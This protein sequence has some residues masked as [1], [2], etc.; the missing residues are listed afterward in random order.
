LNEARAKRFG[1]KSLLMLGLVCELLLL[2]FKYMV[3]NRRN[4]GRIQLKMGGRTSAIFEVDSSQDFI[5]WFE[6]GT[7]TNANGTVKGG[8]AWEAAR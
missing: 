1:K 8:Q 7:V 5:N 2:M 3:F 6:L 4:R